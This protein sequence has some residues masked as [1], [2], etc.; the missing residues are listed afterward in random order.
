MK[1]PWIIMRRQ[2]SHL[3]TTGTLMWKIL[4]QATRGFLHTAGFLV[5]I[6]AA[7]NQAQ[8]QSYVFDRLWPQLP[9]PWYFSFPYGVAVDPSGNVIVVDMDNRRVLVFNSSGTFLRNW[10]SQGSGDGQFSSPNGVAVDL[11]G[12]VIVIDR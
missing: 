2:E 10:G 4:I 1:I 7:T 12:N 8:A 9:Q 5:I 6:A 11:S 3:E